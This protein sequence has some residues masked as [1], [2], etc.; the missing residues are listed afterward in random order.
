MGAGFS[1]KHRAKHTICP[2]SAINE[3]AKECQ[4]DICKPM[5]LK[6]ASVAPRDRHSHLEQHMNSHQTDERPSIDQIVE[7]PTKTVSKPTTLELGY[8][9]M[10][11][12]GTGGAYDNDT[13]KDLNRN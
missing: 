7:S 5:N 10:L 9:D 8:D 3:G 13:M 11:I 1:K 12:G 2:T 6:G 4:P